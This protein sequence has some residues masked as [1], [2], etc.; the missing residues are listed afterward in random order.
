MWGISIFAAKFLKMEDGLMGWDDAGSH[1]RD[2]SLLTKMYGNEEEGLRQPF[3]SEAG[4]DDSV[5]SSRSHFVD[6]PHVRQLCNW[7]CGLACVLMVLR[8]FGMND[9][10]I[11]DLEE[12]CC[13]TSI[14]TVDLAYLLKKFS[15]KFSFFTVTLG[16]NPDFSS[17]A[18]Y[19]VVNTLFEEALEAGIRIEHRSLSGNDISLLMLSGGYIAIALVDKYKLSHSCAKDLYLPELCDGR[20]NYIGH[21]IVICGYDG[22]KDE[23]DIRDPASSRKQERIPLACLEVARKSFGTDEDILL[24]SLNGEGPEVRLPG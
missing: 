5:S 4:Y 24:I 13:T 8:T 15:I 2:A 10:S 3:S 19:K 6:V 7:D 21:F 23:F 1:Q 11:H 14:W 12:F 18:F 9:F 17:E 22:E 16:A 20:P